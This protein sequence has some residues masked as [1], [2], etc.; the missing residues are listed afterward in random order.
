M[1]P[2]W[3]VCVKSPTKPIRGLKGG[4][5]MDK[6]QAIGYMIIALKESG[7]TDKETIKTVM[8][9]M[10]IA[11][12]EY[13]EE[14]TQDVLTEVYVWDGTDYIRQ[15]VSEDYAASRFGRYEGE[16]YDELAYS[17]ILDEDV[18]IDR[19]EE[20]EEEY[21]RNYWNYDELNKEYTEDD[22]AQVYVCSG[23]DYRQMDVALSYA[24][25][26]LFYSEEED[27]YFLSEEEYRDYSEIQITEKETNNN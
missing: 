15:T 10:A 9:N 17:E 1:C 5:K 16:Y 3:R 19:Q 4:L 24:E 27:A 13:N 18:P 23:T 6:E 7:I 14:Y 2:K 22:L 11:I 25:S 12:D 8:R 20:L 21:K 26:E